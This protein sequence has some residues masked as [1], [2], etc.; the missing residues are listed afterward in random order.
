MQAD[1]FP[2]SRP[3]ALTGAFHDYVRGV[4]AD[5]CEQAARL[6]EARARWLRGVAQRMAVSRALQRWENEGGSIR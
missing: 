2:R 4:F 1:V 6:H 5:R 3:Y